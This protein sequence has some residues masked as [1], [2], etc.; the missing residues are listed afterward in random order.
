MYKIKKSLPFI[1]IKQSY[2]NKNVLNSNLNIQYFYN[3]KKI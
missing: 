2:D 3:K 1:I